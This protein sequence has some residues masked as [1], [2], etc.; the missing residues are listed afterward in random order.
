MGFMN[1]HSHSVLQLRSGQYPH[2]TQGECGISEA[3]SFME[4]WGK[5]AVLSSWIVPQTGSHGSSLTVRFPP[6]TLNFSILS[7][8]FPLPLSPNKSFYDLYILDRTFLFSTNH[9]SCAFIV[10]FVYKFSSYIT[11]NDFMSVT[12]KKTR[13]AMS[14]I[15]K[16]FFNS[17][18]TYH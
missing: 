18:E 1:L 13:V 8:P 4:K 5:P 12:K 7:P 11:Q 9:N 2:P 16:K 10:S 6:F 15:K 14:T 17:L 3:L